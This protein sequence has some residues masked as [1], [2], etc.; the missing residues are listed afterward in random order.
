[1]SHDTVVIGASAGGV[2]ALRNL[3]SQLPP[4]LNAAIFVMIHLSPDRPSHLPEILSQ[5]GQLPVHSPKDGEVIKP[6]HIYV[7]RSN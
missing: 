1:M 2:T 6:G 4:D 5:C 7:A 3:V